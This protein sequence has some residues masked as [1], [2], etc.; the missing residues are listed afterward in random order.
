MERHTTMPANDGEG[1][2]TIY[3]VAHSGVDRRQLVGTMWSRHSLRL[4][5]SMEQLS[6]ACIIPPTKD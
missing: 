1:H 3:S 4:L 5:Y 2:M 6:S